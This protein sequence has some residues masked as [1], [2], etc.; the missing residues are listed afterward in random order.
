[1]SNEE[2][3]EQIFESAREVMD[4]V[5]AVHGEKYARTV[6]I[7]LNML[8][9]RELIGHLLAEVEDDIGQQKTESI[10]DGCNT[11]FAHVIS[12]GSAN[13]DIIKTAKADEL[14]NWARKILAIEERGAN[15]LIGND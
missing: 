13:A 14:L 5:R 11:I 6:E 9:L 1:M 2:Q 15:A 10:W 8:K 12:L 3:A 4:S 7:A